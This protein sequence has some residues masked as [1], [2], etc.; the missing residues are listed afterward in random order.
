MRPLLPIPH[1]SMNPGCFLARGLPGVYDVEEEMLKASEQ[2]R[3]FK[4]KWMEFK[5]GIT[6]V[7]V[8][9]NRLRYY[10]QFAPP[11]AGE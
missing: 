4:V 3:W 8:L 6:V 7:S 11:E 5:F 10:R 9:R 1:P 2:G